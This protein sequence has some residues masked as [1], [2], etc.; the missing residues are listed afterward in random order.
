MSVQWT[1]TLFDKNDRRH[2]DF[3]LLAKTEPDTLFVFNDNEEEFPCGTRPGGGNACVRPLR[4]LDPPRAAGIP[5]GSRGRGYA[6]LTPHVKHIIDSA[7]VII[8]SLIATGRYVRVRYS[9]ADNDPFALGTSIFRVSAP[10]SAYIREHIHKR[11]T[12]DVK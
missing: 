10:V 7:F 8:D 6:A 9:C 1:P 12:T 2:T 11:S 4:G 3:R 5:T